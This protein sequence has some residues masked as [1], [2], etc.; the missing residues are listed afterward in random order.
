[1]FGPLKYLNKYLKKYK[2][3]LTTGLFFI[4]IANLF[5]I[6]P[7]IVIRNAFDFVRNNL[8]L[9]NIFKD[10]LLESLI[11]NNLS[12]ILLLFAAIV[13]ISAI[14]KGF[15]TFL[16]RQT[17][18]VM[19]RK[20]EYDLKNE[21]FNHYQ[22]LDLEF[23]KKQSTG[24]LMNRISEDV[25]RVRMYLGPAI[26]YSINLVVLFTLVLTTMLLV[27][28]KLTLF[29]LTPLP[30]LSVSIYY[31]S[32]IIYKKSEKVQR[33]LSNLSTISQETF[34]GI[35][36][37][38]SFAKEKLFSIFFNNETLKYK[39][40]NME[41]VKVDALF[42]PLM[43][44]L[45]GLSTIL[46]ICIGGIATIKGEITPGNIAEFV[47]YVNML[48]W[49]VTSI[50]WVTSLIQRAAASQ[51]RINEFLNTKSKITNGIYIPQKIKGDIEFKNVT[52]IY[53]ES[54]VV[55][56]KNI[57]FKIKHGQK[58]GIIGKTGAG[59]STIASL[60]LRLYDIN[61]GEIL[62]DNK[63]IKDYDIHQLRNYIG[64]VPQDVF[65]FS[66]TIGENISF[67]IKEKDNLKML[68]EAAANAVI[69]NTIEDTPEKF[70][71]I[72][73]ERG[74]NLSGGQKQRLSIARAIIKNPEILIFDDCLSAVDT[75]TEN[76]IL[77]NLKEIMKNKT[78]LIISHRISSIINADKIIVIE[79]G[80]IIEEGTHHELI[81]KKGY[82]YEINMQQKN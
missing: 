1:M 38:K 14:I 43:I 68:K 72:I 51:E 3:R 15:F 32:T 74:V 60:I 17:I 44:L 26:M 59:K 20:I 13:I 42:Q 67:A 30:I 53:P 11:Y 8:Y 76:L 19:S 63:N 78:S 65:L 79:N 6:Y 24:D 47:I 22:Q 71:S 46:T 64:Y 29:V 55:A 48:T 81:K 27:N 12:T 80:K 34:S 39:K 54:G 69:L 31:I 66:D 75:V 62:I 4:I 77:E 10:S 18:I 82:Y 33:Q 5:A 9:F 35:R 7:A 52:F 40:I 28:V 45:I 61:E 57:S 41:L 16:M 58:L 2:W 36:V 56:L 50:G 70:N 23:F 25:N 37:V 21:I 49:P 73:G